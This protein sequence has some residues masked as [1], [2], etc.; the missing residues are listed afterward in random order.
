MQKSILLL[1][2]F[3]F[4]FGFNA[5]DPSKKTA[6]TPTLPPIDEI[7]DDGQIEVVF[8]H[9]NDVYEIAPLEGGKVG[10]LARVATIREQL[11]E[12]NPLVVTVLAGDF[13]NPSLIGTLK[14][15]GK[16]IKGKH[17]V[18]TMNALK[19]D[20]VT[21]GNHEFD[22]KEH[23]LQERLNES[24]FEWVVANVLQRDSSG[25]L[26]PFA[27]IVNGQHQSLPKTYQL[28]MTD[29]DGTNVSIG[30]LSVCLDANKKEYVHYDDV[31]ESATQAYGEMKEETDLV[32]GLT[33][34]DIADDKELA[35]KLPALPLVMGG[36]DHDNMIFHIGETT[37]AKA[38]ANAKTVYVHRLFINKINGTVKVK[39]ELVTID[40][41]IEENTEVAA[42]VK[43]W[44]DIA[45][46]SL[47]EEGFDPDQIITTLKEPLDGREK[48]MRNGPTNMGE[49]ITKAMLKAAPKSTAAIVNSGS[50]RLDDFLEGSITE[51]DI[52]R[53]LPFGG[54]IAEV[55]LS[56]ELLE[57]I[58][59]V[60]RE[61][62][63]SG[64][65]LQLQKLAYVET[66]DIWKIDG[67]TL[68]PTATYRI[69]LTDFLLTGLEK[70][71]DFL[72]PDNPGIFKVYRPKAEEES[73]L[74]Q[75]IR[76]A[77]IDYLE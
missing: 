28:N 55:D 29:E 65:Y 67:K 61:N 5:C 11:L 16:R 31:F 69:A 38:D 60:G 48:T 37:V 52:I 41:S 32:I 33:H 66:D 15:E 17:M 30:I 22:I 35:K 70:D 27:K 23:E 46:K 40:D 36:H 63:G 77:I 7:V 45:D 42:V 56:G 2:L 20:L 72:T 50:V 19:V 10:G 73:D 24:N 43:K 4:L 76:K 8:L 1:T 71:L 21:L 44:D 62:K 75:D 49:V 51:V 13:L 58:L 54:S 26:S 12:E 3:A 25:N 6:K 47:I 68:N 64:G 74:R 34:L 9:L 18:E 53:T 59:V 57:E 14:H 39:S